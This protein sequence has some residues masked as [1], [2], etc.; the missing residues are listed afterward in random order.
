MPRDDTAEDIYLDNR[1]NMPTDRA[2]Q[3]GSGKAGLADLAPG[4]RN[5]AFFSA[6]V[7]DQRILER[8]RKISDA[9]SRNLIGKGEARNLLKDFLKAEG[10]DD[11]TASL[12]N[13]AS[14]ARL[15]L[16]LEQNSKMANA[17]GR[18]QAMM[19]PD[20]LKA[21]PCVIYR[22]SVGSRVPRPEHQQYDGMVF[23]KDDPWLRAHWPPSKFGCNCELEEC[24]AK[25]A[26]RLGVQ[27]RTPPEKAAVTSE[28]GFAF[29][30]ANAFRAEQ[31]D[32]LPTPESRADM[33]ASIRQYVEREQTT[34]VAS[35]RNQ[36]PLTKPPVTRL[37]AQKELA[38]FVA[39]NRKIVENPKALRDDAKLQL[40]PD[41]LPLGELSGE[42]ADSLGL[43]GQ[44]SQIQLSRGNSS[45][46]LFH[47]IRRHAASLDDGELVGTIRRL[48][49]GKNVRYTLSMSPGK[50][51]ILNIEEVGGPG[52]I[53]LRRKGGDAAWEVV[54][55]HG[56]EGPAGAENRAR[57]NRVRAD[58]K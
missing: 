2:T 31:I 18:Y 38:D 14:T 34:F 58:R 29:D 47:Q 16:I 44:P 28:S 27:P 40:V 23:Y 32:A 17:V 12:R 25:Q 46:G 55:A 36:R 57:Y 26:A 37:P 50:T 51:D 8:L 48:L 22:A 4:I 53:T 49:G 3:G 45:F 11:G 52:L 7:A 10:Q 15:N 41:K 42:V 20:V 6:R 30:P 54:S 13:L 5:R 56:I 19:D 33:L 43:A 35:A 39:A 21:F 1:V 9:Y 24:S